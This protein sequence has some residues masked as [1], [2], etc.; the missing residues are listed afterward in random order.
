MVTPP[1]IE[2]GYEQKPLT[3]L[4]N[5]FHAPTAPQ[6]HT[7]NGMFLKMSDN[8]TEQQNL[9]M[10]N[11]FSQNS[12]SIL[13]YSL[14]YKHYLTYINIILQNINYDAAGS[15]LNSKS[16]TRQAYMFFITIVMNN[17]MFTTTKKYS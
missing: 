6:R 1:G 4:Q 13:S 16:K 7:Q 12:K 3:Q 9:M 8:N 15:D 2:P 17:I 11:R 10:I 14:P 5:I